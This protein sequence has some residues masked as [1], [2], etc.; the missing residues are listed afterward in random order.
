MK[1]QLRF[2]SLFVF[3]FLSS[4]LRAEVTE[5]ERDDFW[6]QMAEQYSRN[7]QVVYDDEK[8]GAP[9][10]PAYIVSN[11]VSY[12]TLNL[13]EG[14]ADLQVGFGTTLNFNIA[15]ARRPNALLIADQSLEAQAMIA[16]FYRPLFLI[17]ETPEQFVAHLAG[18]VPKRRETVDGLFKRVA[19]GELPSA[20]AI[21]DLK[22]KLKPLIKRG[23]VTELDAR[24][25]ELV[26][27]EQGASFQGKTVSLFRNAANVTSMVKDFAELYDID[28]HERRIENT[29]KWQVHNLRGLLPTLVQDPNARLDED[30][31]N[32]QKNAILD[33][34]ETSLNRLS[35]LTGDGFSTVKNLFAK[36]AVF[37]AKGAIEK[38]ALWKAI[39]KFAEKRK[40][41]ISDVY[42]SNIPH[43]LKESQ[44]N[45][46]RLALIKHFA[47]PERQDV[48]M[49]IA[50]LDQ[51]FAFQSG[52]VIFR[53]DGQIE[54][55]NNHVH[56]PHEFC[57]R[58]L[59]D[60]GKKN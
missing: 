39:T 35:F 21:E 16:S 48:L 27:R 9:S 25:I 52:G 29:Y 56:P 59:R 26:L 57:F 23:L 60:L 22:E 8:T 10:Y 53:T 36:D 13:P 17:S 24:F 58:T 31:A 42:F 19:A 33:R 15:A 43:I 49:Y 28:T 50:P 46:V 12:G 34:Q 51:R 11:E 5:R 40:Q 45:Q 54:S 7:Q 1:T 38:D 30:D 44:S 14:G 37:L 32:R 6:R 55:L 4:I 20:K 41:K 3:L 18:L 2:I 47:T